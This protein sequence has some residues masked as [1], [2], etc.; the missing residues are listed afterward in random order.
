[1]N[2]RLLTNDEIVDLRDAL[3]AHGP[4]ATL[5]VFDQNLLRDCEIAL[6]M[7]QCSP[8]SREQAR[9]RATRLAADKRALAEFERTS[10]GAPPWSDR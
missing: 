10:G 1:M 4:V 7:V 5:T 2:E 9:W 3:L 6:G 8:E